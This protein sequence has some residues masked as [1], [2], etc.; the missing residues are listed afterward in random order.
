[1]GYYTDFSLRVE[2][3]GAAYGRLMDEQ[4]RVTVSESYEF[5]LGDFL[6]NGQSDVKWYDY[7]D[8]MKSLSKRWPNVLFIL[9]GDGEEQGD[10]WRA[11]Y[12]NGKGIKVEPTFLEPDLDKLLPLDYA[13][14]QKMLDERRAEIKA[15]MAQLGKELDKLD[16]LETKVDKVPGK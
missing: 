5:K 7:D 16:G 8:D 11:W 9:D 4:D 2:G 15:R 13:I 3:S 6:R 10:V 14:E 1:M 12:R